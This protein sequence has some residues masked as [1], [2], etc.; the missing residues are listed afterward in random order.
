MYRTA[1]GEGK[2]PEEIF[3]DSKRPRHPRRD[4]ARWWCR[5]SARRNLRTPS[6]NPWPSP[7]TWPSAALAWSWPFSASPPRKT[8]RSAVG[9]A[10]SREHS[11][12]GN[13]EHFSRRSR[14]SS[15]SGRWAGAPSNRRTRPA[16]SGRRFRANSPGSTGV[17][18]RGLWH[19]AAMESCGEGITP[20]RRCRRPRWDCRRRWRCHCCCWCRSRCRGAAWWRRPWVAVCGGSA[21]WCPRGWTALTVGGLGPRDALFELMHAQLFLL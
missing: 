1:R 19:P 13:S 9:W 10:P 11:A 17:W 16:E 7:R 20:W 12:V 8:V 6:R 21:R 15:P 3:K 4:G 14:E 2:E 18:R 5:R